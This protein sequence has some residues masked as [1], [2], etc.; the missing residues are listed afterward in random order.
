MRTE[1]CDD[2]EV[3]VRCLICRQEVEMAVSRGRLALAAKWV[4][5]REL[6]R[7]WATENRSRDMKRSFQEANSEGEIPC[8]VKEPRWKNRFSGCTLF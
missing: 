6:Q 1:A 3:T 5:L 4:C 2:K 7:V 8:F